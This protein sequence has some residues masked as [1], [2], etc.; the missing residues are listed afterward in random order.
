MAQ[1][2]YSSG[3]V[4]AGSKKT[5]T[6]PQL[7]FLNNFADEDNEDEDDLKN[8]EEYMSP[9]SKNRRPAAH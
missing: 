1:S 6:S 2:S 7:R 5:P 9:H 4:S 8:D 3:I